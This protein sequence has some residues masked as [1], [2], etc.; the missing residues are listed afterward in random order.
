MSEVLKAVG[1]PRLLLIIAREEDERRIQGVLGGMHLPIC[2]QIR[3]QGTATSEWLDICGLSG[4][5]RVL[6]LALMPRK[7]TQYV[8]AGLRRALSLDKRGKGVAVTVPVR[9]LQ[10]SMIHLLGDLGDRVALGDATKGDEAAMGSNTEYSMVCVA[11][12][13]G[14]SEDVVEAA[15]SAGARGGTVLKGIRRVDG[16]TAQ[17]MGMAVQEEQDIAIVIIPRDKK[18]DVMGAISEKCGLKTPAHGIVFS[19]PI[20]ETLGLQ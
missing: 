6:T 15:R 7:M 17:F 13:S 4:T 5:T 19:M 12:N 16:K 8:L 20:D 11:V 1:Y 3:G 14:Y 10:S 9:G 18:Q 2:H